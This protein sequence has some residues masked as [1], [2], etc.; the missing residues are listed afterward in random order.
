LAPAIPA[1]IGLAA[2]FQSPVVGGLLYAWQ[3]MNKK[4]QLNRTLADMDKDSEILKSLNDGGAKPDT[5]YIIIGGDATKY[6]GPADSG[7]SRL[8]DKLLTGVGDLIYRDKSNDVAVL[9]DDIFQ[10]KGRDNIQEHIVP[11]HHMIYFSDEA[12]MKVLKGVL[13]A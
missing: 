6:E 7:F 11:C 10:I 13:N 3:W 12:S 1:L 8:M 9:L 4:G 2:N 5:E